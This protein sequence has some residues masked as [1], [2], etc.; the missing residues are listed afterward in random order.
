MGSRTARSR[1]V[2]TAALLALG[3]LLG[4][5]RDEGPQLVA[6]DSTTQLYPPARLALAPNKQ[7]VA[8]VTAGEDR[9][10]A[11]YRADS[12]GQAWELLA[13]LPASAATGDVALTIVE[14]CALVVGADGAR[15]WRA[16]LPINAPAPAD[17]FLLL[18]EFDAGAPVLSLA[19]DATR[20]HPGIP[21]YVHLVY[22]TQIPE[23][24]DRSLHYRH[25]ID[26]G[27]TWSE[28]RILAQ[29][30]IG[31]PALNCHADLTGQV[32]LCFRR[33]EFMRYL[34]SASNGEEWIPEKTI[35]LEAS[36]GGRTAIARRGREVL[37]VCENHLHQV[38]G[39]TSLNG[40]YNWEQI[41]RA[42]V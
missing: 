6:L 35:R 25:S 41:G 33:A 27:R 18:G 30:V 3:L 20:P 15:I 22:L 19:V 14:Q 12:S 34:G 7:L 32:D 10:L 31:R 21:A 16:L 9:H 24:G 28:A 38:A 40:G 39:A 26:H 4:C 11:L 42:H 1:A 36:P 2:G 13:H 8:L 17:S 29:G 23:A 5:G 37:V